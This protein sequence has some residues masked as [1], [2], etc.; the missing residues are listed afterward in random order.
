[1]CQ[2]IW[3]WQQFTQLSRFVSDCKNF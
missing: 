1:L 2:Q 3:L